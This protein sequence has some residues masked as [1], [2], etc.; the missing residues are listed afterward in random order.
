MP[1]TPYKNSSETKKRQVAQMFDNIAPK[2]DFLNHF[3]SFNIDKLW[4]KKA[5]N[6]LKKKKP[7]QILD[8][9]TG[10]GDF[11]I[12]VLKL[13]PVKVT[14]IDISSEMLKIAEQKVKNKKLPDVFEF[15]CCDSENLP[16]NDNNFDAA[17]VAFGVRNFENLHV[18]LCQINRVL[19]TGAPFVVLE[20]SKPAYFPAKQFYHFY[21]FYILP[22][23]GRLFSK[24]ASAYTYL[25]ESIQAFPEGQTF[26]GELQ[27]A[28]FVNLK[29]NRL[30]F[31]VATIYYAEKF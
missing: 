19:R 16:F 31:G 17:T 27:L 15:L 30:T 26:L 21:S 23:I 4:R 14:G 20:F 18:G 1:V 7:L 8:I 10:T 2:Y 13:N 11:A 9:A 29:Q 6:M 5:V 3:L 25:P 12:A 22:F 24:D 28:G